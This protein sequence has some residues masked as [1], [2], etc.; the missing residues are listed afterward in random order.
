MLANKTLWFHM[1]NFALR[2]SADG[3]ICA[4]PLQYLVPTRCRVGCLFC[5]FSPSVKVL[6]L[7]AINKLCPMVSELDRIWCV[8]LQPAELLL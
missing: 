4:K 7:E 5:Y 2:K 3:V 1:L 8:D 6:D